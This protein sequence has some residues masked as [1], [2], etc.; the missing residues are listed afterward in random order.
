MTESTDQDVNGFHYFRTQVYANLSGGEKL[1]Q[2]YDNWAEYY[3]KQ[4]GSVGYSGPANLAALASDVIRDK[5]SRILDAASGTGMVGEELKRRGFT[6]IDA[7]DPSQG[8]LDKSKEHQSYTE[9]ICDTLDEHQTTVPDSH[10][11]AV[12]MCGAFGIPGHVSDACFPELIRITKP[13]GH[14]MITMSTKVSEDWNDKLEAAI[15]SHV[16]QGS[17]EVVDDRW[18]TYHEH[19]TINEKAKVPILRVVKK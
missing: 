12:V 13:G 2:V 18:I 1:S 16:Q 7:L 3:T 15:Q 17:W 14:I 11:D 9:Y 4:T 5:S 8:S 6:N 10:Y 19:D